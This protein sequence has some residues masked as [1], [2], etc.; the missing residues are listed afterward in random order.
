MFRSS[1]QINKLLAQRPNPVLLRKRDREQRLMFGPAVGIPVANV[2]LVIDQCS[3]S[4]SLPS[5]VTFLDSLQ[6][7]ILVDGIRKHENTGIRDVPEVSRGRGRERSNQDRRLWRGDLGR[8]GFGMDFDRDRVDVLNFRFFVRNHMR[9]DTRSQPERLPALGKRNLKRLDRGF[10]RCD[11]DRL[12]VP[13]RSEIERQPSIQ[14]DLEKRVS[15][16]C[17]PVPC[18]PRE[19][20]CAKCRRRAHEH[21]PLTPRACVG[22]ALGG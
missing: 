13:T 11:I 6:L 4:P 16:T 8:I 9:D 7:A 17:P 2:S 12:F 19:L 10:N 5:L 15:D 1:K 22:G 20:L 18:F 21:P 14:Y 3:G